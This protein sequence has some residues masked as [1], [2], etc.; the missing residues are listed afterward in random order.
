MKPGRDDAENERNAEGTDQRSPVATSKIK[1]LAED[2]QT[3]GAN[4]REEYDEPLADREPVKKEGEDGTESVRRVVSHR[5]TDAH[6]KVA[7]SQVDH[8]SFSV[9][10]LPERRPSTILSHVGI[11]SFQ[12]NPP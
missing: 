7:D 4:G 9:V 11:D 1:F 3:A 8:H 6:E 2:N 5:V 10:P 12:L